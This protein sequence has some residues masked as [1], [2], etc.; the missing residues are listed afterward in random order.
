MKLAKQMLETVLG[1]LR[2]DP[3]FGDFAAVAVDG[4]FF[5]AVDIALDGKG[6]RRLYRLAVI[7][8]PV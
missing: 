1:Y 8:R 6:G 3:S 2:R 5:S 4:H 7:R